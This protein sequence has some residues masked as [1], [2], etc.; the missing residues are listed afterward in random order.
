M[1]V[2]SRP[3]S[4]TTLSDGASSRFRSRVFL[5]FKLLFVFFAVDV[6]VKRLRKQSFKPRLLK[7]SKKLGTIIVKGKAFT[8]RRSI[9]RSMRVCARLSRSQHYPF[10]IKQENTKWLAPLLPP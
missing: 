6:V 3:F 7:T 2:R 10:P 1:T 9:V 5:F 4:G 8:L